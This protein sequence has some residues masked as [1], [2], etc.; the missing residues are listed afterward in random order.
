MRIDNLWIGKFKNL[1]D[2]S[3]DFDE[4]QLTSVLIGE[5]GTGKSNII[6]ALITIFRNLD[7]GQPPA[8][9]YKIKY[10]CRGRSIEIDA[11]PDS[12]KKYSGVTVDG[13]RIS[14]SR[15]LEGK[16]RYLP[17]YVFAYYSG[18]NRRIESLFDRHQRQFSE[19][20]LG[21]D[22]K[23]L[24]PLFLCRLEHS[25][26]VLLAYFSFADNASHEFL[27]DYLG[28]TGLESV[29]F[30]LHEPWWA[31]NRV[32]V[33]TPGDARFWNARGVVSDFLSELWDSSLAPIYDTA[34][35][36]EDYRG[37]PVKERR[38]Y[39]F[40]KDESSLRSLASNYISQQEFFKHLE[41]LYISDL[42]REVRVRVARRGVAD[43][44][45]FRELSEGEQQLLTVMG[46]LKFTK[47]EES[48]FLLDEP[49]THLNPAWKLDYLSL[50]ERVV[51]ANST[52]HLLIATHDPL[53]IAG[54]S[55]GQ[56]QMLVRNEDGI[57]AR[58]P[59]VDPRG[60]G[61]AGVLHQMFGLP[62]T[63]DPETQGKLDRRNYLF[64]KEDR[65]EREDSE[66]RAL[67]DE[68]AEL[69]FTMIFRDPLY[70]RFVRAMAEREISHRVRLTPEEVKLQEQVANMI[71]DEIMTEAT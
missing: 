29:L 47:D 3:I 20:L 44:V 64:A 28:I 45:I 48:L 11:M 67:S 40:L 43:N 6:E 26:F 19:A 58:P 53:V 57:V 7:L 63:L 46:L 25:A 54:L 39:L 61:V 27:R 24:R 2:F 38:L 59:S 55:R 56:V 52:S 17:N 42:V 36:Q 41:S 16:R 69:G 68:L 5:N 30:V 33:T 9:P 49:D 1:V 66:M 65:T 34:S 31:K 12:R 13:S 23:P 35:I 4:T 60:L 14:F 10:Q 37:Q 62:S 50:L 51:G 22:R 32:Q 8:F 15:F 71:L 21:G 18:V 70:S